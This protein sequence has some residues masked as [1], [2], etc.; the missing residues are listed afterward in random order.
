[1]NEMRPLKTTLAQGADHNKQQEGRRGR[2]L[3]I[4]SCTD[5][6]PLGLESHLSSHYLIPS[7]G[8]GYYALALLTSRGFLG[9]TAW[10]SRSLLIRRMHGKTAPGALPSCGS[11][12]RTLLDSVHDQG[13]YALT[14]LPSRGVKPSLGETIEIARSLVVLPGTAVPGAS[15]VV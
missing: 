3:G 7:H 11:P 15:R 12:N 13:C 4:A 2:V 8:Q 14:L 9:H 1:M 10:W 6:W 5:T